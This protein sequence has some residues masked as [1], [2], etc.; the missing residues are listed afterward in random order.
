MDYLALIV[1]IIGYAIVAWLLLAIGVII[2]IPNTGSSMSYFDLLIG[3]CRHLIHRIQLRWM[4]KVPV[5]EPVDPTIVHTPGTCGGRARI[6]G[7]RI[8]V[9]LIELHRRYG[10]SVEDTLD[11]YPTLNEE[12]V[13]AALHYAD[14][15]PAEIDQDIRDQAEYDFGVKR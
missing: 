6:A 5:E 15:H 10:H 8:A 13:L 12:Q 7:H 3:R 4:K 2:F 14:H 1:A 9:W 11:T